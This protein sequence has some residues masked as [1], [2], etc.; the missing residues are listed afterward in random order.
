MGYHKQPTGPLL[1]D[2]D[3]PIL[4]GIGN[5]LAESLDVS[6]LSHKQVLLLYMVLGRCID[7]LWREFP[8]VLLPLVTA[9]LEEDDE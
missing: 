5:W 2:M 6:K 4:V 9:Q 3:G 8:K 1:E 7:A